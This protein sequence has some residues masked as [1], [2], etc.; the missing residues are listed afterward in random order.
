MTTDRMKKMARGML[1]LAGVLM[2]CLGLIA[3]PGLVEARA[4]GVTPRAVVGYMSKSQIFAFMEMASESGNGCDGS[5]CYSYSVTGTTWYF[6][7]WGPGYD[8][9]VQGKTA[10]DYVEEGAS[11]HSWSN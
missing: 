9:T 11:D 3:A 10:G 6:H 4:T 5:S 2:L 7:E 8:V 1:L